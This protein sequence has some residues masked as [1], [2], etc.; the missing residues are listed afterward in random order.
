MKQW[1]HSS[2]KLISVLSARSPWGSHHGARARVREHPRRAGGGRVGEEPKLQRNG[3]TG[4]M[5]MGGHRRDHDLE[6]E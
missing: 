4:G 5:G 1:G 2:A 3:V 6:N